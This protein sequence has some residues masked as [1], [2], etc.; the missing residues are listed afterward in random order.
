MIQ[1]LLPIF[2]EETTRINDYIAYQKKDGK[3][4]YFNGTMPIF[5]HPEDDNAS[6]R[7]YTSQ[8]YI[9]GMCK[10]VEIVRAFG[11]SPITVKRDAK[12]LR[13]EGAGAFFNKPAR[14]ST[15][16]VLTPEVKEM[17]QKMLNNGKSRAEISEELNIRSDTLYR[18]I[19]NGS[20][21]EPELKV[22]D[23]SIQ[24][25]RSIADS[26]AEMGMGCTRVL[27]RVA[28]SVGALEVVPTR[29]EIA[30][31]VPNGGVLCALPALL[32]NGLLEY[33]TEHFRIPKG[34][35]TIVHIFLLLALMA[36]ARI[37]N[38]EKLKDHAPGE[39]GKLLGLDRVPEVKTL[40]EKIKYVAETGKVSEWGGTLSKKWMES[41]P[42]A[43]GVLYVDGMVRTYNGKQARLPRRYV[44][45]QKLCMRGMTDY[46]VNDQHSRPFFV[47]TTP[48]T[49]G[50]LEMLKNEIVPRLLEDVP[51]QPDENDLKADR[52]LNR[53]VLIFDRE[54]YSPA[55]FEEMW[56]R[57]IACQTYHKYPGSNW[58][59]SE[60]KEHEVEVSLGRRVTMNLAER[61]TRF[62]KHHWIREIRKLTENGHQVPVLS[63]D[64][65]A[66]MVA[67]AG[68][69]FSRWSQENFFKYMRKHYNIQGLI[70]YNTEPADE[71]KEVIN[72]KYREL[73]GKIRSKAAKLSR[74]KVEFY[75]FSIDERLK[76]E[77]I[78]EYEQKRGELREEI[79]LLEMDVNKFKAEK[80]KVPKHIKLGDLPE[81]ERFKT[82]S[83]VRKQFIDLI[84]MI[85]YRA[86]TAMAMVMRGFSSRPDDV[87]SLLQSLFSCS[88]NLIPNI[89]EKKLTIQLHHF[90]N[91]L[92]DRIISKLC[93][94]L[95]ETETKYPGTEMVLDFKLVSD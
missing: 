14:K 80:K 82:L 33:T 92:T 87:R 47:V 17:A 20:L 69:M 31:D 29:F 35:Y 63:T 39:W 7:M 84:K 8:L 68:H 27:E 30:Y 55:F 13:E 65:K 45:R 2:F 74:K 91:P 38:V 95:N 1:L 41:D 66:E 61:G 64:Y 26:K 56:E 89:E 18:A 40:R 60:F 78:E 70:E 86:E 93:E 48:F 15:P 10:Q 50:L 52:Y 72:P 5:V 53:L 32:A 46:W 9:N 25:D 79:D 22:K 81:N 51:D 76:A 36:L 19:K 59:E 77:D 90:C 73:E 67:I 71:T 3:I 57:R 44:A 49:S 88:A 23:G 24:S 83:P 94:Y 21:T 62:G 16:R 4:F 58:P 43:A 85:A 12:Q 42:E 34:F 6:F 11:V 28:S 75:N 37:K 54:G